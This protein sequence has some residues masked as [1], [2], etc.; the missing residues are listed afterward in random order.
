MK[1]NTM[2][3][4]CLMLMAKVL[5]AQQEAQYTQFMFSKI[6][7]NPAVAGSTETGCLSVI[8]RSQW[9]GLEGAPTSQMINFQKPFFARKV[10]FGMSL[11]HDAIG[12]TKVWTYRMMYSYRIALGAHH[13]A[14]GL[15][16]GLKR[17]A[18]RLSDE[19]RTH[20]GDE[21]IAM[22]SHAKILPNIG[23]GLYLQSD[24]YFLGLSMPNVLKGDLTFYDSGLQNSDISRE[25]QYFYLMGGLV[26]D[27]AYHI[28]FKPAV[29]VK[30][31]AHAPVVADLN[32]SIIFLE[33]LWIGATY[34]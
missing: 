28:K 30:Y 9:V 18:L 26:L 6:A 15:Q 23:M 29:L 32:A 3:I 12:P 31:N 5:S 11:S 21:A 33:K 2:I 10:G 8:H 22:G 1:K 20:E 25:E 16:G 19:V 17:Y 13:L 34:R 14:I 7:L 24:N 27:L 4:F